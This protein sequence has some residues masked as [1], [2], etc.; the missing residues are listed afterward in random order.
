M[1]KLSAFWDR[2]QSSYWFVPAAMNLGAIVLF[3]VM[4]WLDQRL[5]PHW[6]KEWILSSR[7]QTARDLL[8]TVA[9]SIITVGGVAFSVTIGA[10][11]YS[12]TQFGPRLLTN[13]LKDR[14]NQVALGTFI[15]VFLYS[16]LV[17]MSIRG[18]EATDPEI[19]IPH[20]AILCNLLL[21]FFSLG[22][23]IFF[24]NHVLE[25]VHSFNVLGRIG[26][27]FNERVDDLFPERIGKGGPETLEHVEEVQLPPGFERQ[28]RLIRVEKDGYVQAVDDE[29]LFEIA[30]KYDLLLKLI[31]RPGDFVNQGRV[32]ILAWP[33]EPVTD[34]MAEDLADM[35]V[36]GNQRT[37]YQD[38]MFLTRELIEF[39]AR[40][41][42]PGQNDPYT[43]I[44]CINWLGSNLV[45]LSGRTTPD[46]R[47]FDERKQLRVVAEPLAFD[48]LADTIFDSLRPY[49]KEDPN[50]SAHLMD[51]IRWISPQLH[52]SSQRQVLQKHAEALK[53]SCD[54]SLSKD[55]NHTIICDLY[56]DAIDMLTSRR[57]QYADAQP[58][59]ASRSARQQG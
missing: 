18:A 5:P 49:V 41:L 47:R 1:I 34:E 20:L 43:A 11:A 56:R 48:R 30:C 23:L 21:V 14:G 19:F 24:F 32:V 27:Q 15:A 38:T 40:A 2:A 52:T 13:F 44:N 59:S 26:E 45:C 16:I 39:A 12:A 33:G 55:R 9:G 8:G 7:P 53:N 6:I 31:H 37:P 28:S 46:P 51:M 3:G 35:F 57:R 10:I 29:K 36:I 4:L 22:V 17:L 25:S 58:P 50:V 54:E 42:S